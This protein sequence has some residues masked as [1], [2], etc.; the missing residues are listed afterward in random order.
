MHPVIKKN[1]RFYLPLLL[2]CFACTSVRAQIRITRQVIATSVFSSTPRGTRQRLKMTATAG[3][4]FV[5][6]QN[7]DVRATVGFQQPDDDVTVSILA[8]GER[9][10]PVKAYPNPTTDR[11]T[12]DLGEAA[13]ELSEVALLD[14]HG[15][16]M[17]HR[18]VSASLLLFPEV[19]DLPG[20]TYFLRGTDLTGTTHGLG[21]VF[22][23]T[24]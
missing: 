24:H 19:A 4:V 12:V 9:R 2:V 3:E 15:R 7:G 10:I 17:L 13:S 16:V 11:L 14:L 18:T 6:T 1:L 22:V 21:T 20:G 23:T 5:G 8:F